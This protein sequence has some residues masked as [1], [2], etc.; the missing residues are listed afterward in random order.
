MT[1]HAP[2]SRSSDHG[3]NRVGF[4]MAGL[5]V[6]GIAG[7]TLIGLAH[8]DP[9]SS[10]WY[11]ATGA[12]IVASWGIARTSIARTA[13][14]VLMPAW[15]VGLAAATIATAIA[16]A[17]DP[18]EAMRIDVGTGHPNLLAAS[19]AVAG[20]ATL[21]LRG[22]TLSRRGRHA[23]WI[24][25]GI[26]LLVV[27]ALVLT[28]SRTG[29]VAFLLG[30]FAAAALRTDPA[31]ARRSIAVAGIV[32]ATA[33]GAMH[34]ALHQERTARN[35]LHASGTV[36]TAPWRPGADAE[37][38]LTP[39][40][41]TN[42][43]VPDDATHIAGRIGGDGDILVHGRL[44]RS[45]AGVDYVA[46]TYLRAD[47]PTRIGL[48]TNLSRVTCDV[49]PT[50]SRCVTPPG[51]GDGTTYVQFRLV[52]PSDVFDVDVTLAAPQLERGR[53]ATT[54]VA[55]G[56]T[57]LPRPL[58][59][60]FT[61]GS[62]LDG[63][64]R[65]LAVARVAVAQARTSPWIGV[66]RE[67]LR[68]A[69]ANADGPTDVTH[70]THAHNLLLQRLAAE[71]VLG[72]LSWAFLLVPPV[73]AAARPR[74]GPTVAVVAT[75]LAANTLDLTFFYAGALIPTFVALGL[76]SMD[77]RRDGPPLSLRHHHPSPPPT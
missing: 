10:L 32:L 40:E 65:R 53:R 52:A 4:T 9:R 11:A 17:F 43:V 61:L 29:L 28:G 1:G 42:E 12:L 71:G 46:S 69:I 23:P 36:S 33:W 8:G 59:E 15:T 49:G 74:P 3:P 58:L 68:H 21:A 76:L 19:L 26:A 63:D 73:V 20:V 51:R 37:L 67:D 39:D 44:G 38:V 41:A 24:D 35:L 56:A 66:G 5:A 48:T 13:L 77:A 54:Y 47:T 34:L 64:A 18:S 70:L 72:L 6:V 60:R 31:G 55:K 25:G 2:P 50:W 62:I 27:G 14:R 30:S 75:V 22:P 45:E 57:L 7:L 16:G